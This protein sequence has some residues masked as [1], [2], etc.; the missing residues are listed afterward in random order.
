MNLPE[1]KQTN[2]PTLQDLTSDLGFAV[3]QDQLNHLLNNEVPKQW[4]KIHPMAK[5][6]YL[7]IDKVEYL[8]TK[9]FLHWKVEV[10]QISQLFNSVSVT[11]RLH[12]RNPINGEFSYFDG[13]GAVGI[14]VNKGSIASDLTS[15]KH[16]AVM[17]ALP[18]AKSYAI[19]DAAEHLGKIFGRD[20]SRTDTLAHNMSY[21][22]EDTLEDL[23]TLYNLKESKLTEQEKLSASRIIMNKEK[24][25]YS[26]LSEILKSK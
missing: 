1:K 19:K 2:L 3:K 17:K 12:Y 4:I 22:V 14:Q 15:I 10:L 20:L 7:P 21:S 18:A 8:L 13:V 11:V 23:T 9:I 6:S 5:T 26:K 25:S 16:D 24:D